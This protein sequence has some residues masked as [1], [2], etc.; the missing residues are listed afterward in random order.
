MGFEVDGS[1]GL[2]RRRGSGTLF[3]ACNAHPELRKGTSRLMSVTSLHRIIR[4]CLLPALAAASVMTATGCGT[5]QTPAPPP[6]V[7]PAS[8]SVP[9]SASMPPSVASSASDA[10]VVE[11][12]IKGGKVNP[13][14]GRVSIAKGQKVRLVVHSDAP[15]EIHVHGYDR[16]AKVGPGQDAV[17][18][19]VADQTGLFEVETH[20]TGLLLTQ[21][22]V[23]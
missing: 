6:S 5:P 16:E 21:L 15:D 10:H 2:W 22:L 23:R 9:P 12:T 18:E 13:P 8:A 11:I 1:G 19:F 4:A 3:C 14:P 7:P 20:G 17:I